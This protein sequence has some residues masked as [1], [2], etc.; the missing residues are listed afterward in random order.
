MKKIF[1]FNISNQKLINLL[2]D[3]HYD[4]DFI[5]NEMLKIEDIIN[6]KKDK[7]VIL[8]KCNLLLFFEFTDK[9]LDLILKLLKDNN[10][11]C[12]FKAIVTKYNVSWTVFKL[13]NELN[14]EKIRMK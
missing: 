4:Y 5:N 9:D 10:I 6:G 1:L 12:D 14:L 13:L 3:N 2:N 8:H 7:E 11:T